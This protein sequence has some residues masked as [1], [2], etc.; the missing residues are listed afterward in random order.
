MGARQVR[1]NPAITARLGL[2]TLALGAL[3]SLCA[4]AAGCGPAEEHAAPATPSAPPTAAAP[5]AEIAPRRP[6]VAAPVI[7][8]DTSPTDA[9]ISHVTFS[10]EGDPERGTIGAP[11]DRYGRTDAFFAGVVVTGGRSGYHLYAKWMGPRG[12][13]LTEYGVFV[14]GTSPQS[15]LALS[16]P[17]GWEPGRH[18]LELSINGGPASRHGVTVE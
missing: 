13:T 4:L 3:A 10:R 14:D 16:R 9:R 6:E 12:D 2:R 5:A 17:G 18:V 7:V 8:R 11:V 15:V 1:L